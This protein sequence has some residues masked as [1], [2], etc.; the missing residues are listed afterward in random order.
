MPIAR[1]LVRRH[2]VYYWRRRIPRKLATCYIR[3]HVLVSLLTREPAR[4]RSIAAQLDA[5]FEIIMMSPDAQFLTRKQI[6]AMLRAVV[7]GHLAKLDRVAAAG[8]TAP[9]FDAAEAAC[10]DLRVAWAYRLLDGQ[11]ADAVVRPDDRVAMTQA[12]LTEGDIDFID[13]HLDVLRINGMVPTPHGNLAALVAAQGARP[14]AMNIALAQQVYYRGL[15]LALFETERRYAGVVPDAE[16][17]V[18]AAQ[19]VD[20]TEA[21]AP[22]SAQAQ[23]AVPAASVAAQAPAEP[24]SDSVIA[25]GIVAA[26]ER[27][28]AVKAQDENWDTETQDQARQTFAL[29]NRFLAEERKINGFASLRQSD[30]ASFVMFLRTEIYKYYGKSKSDKTRTI[31]ELKKNAAAKDQTLRGLVGGTLNRHLGHIGQLARYARAQG[32]RIDRE[33][34]FGDLRAE[35]PKNI[36]DRD[37]RNTMP[38]AVTQRVFHA[39]HFIGSASWDRPYEFKKEGLVFH[40]ALFFVPMLLEYTGTRREESCGLCVDDIH[41]DGPIPYIHIGRNELRRIKNPQSVRDIPLHPELLRLNFLKYVDLIRSLGYRRVFPDLYSPTSKSPLGDRFYDEFMP[42]LEWACKMENVDLEFVLHSIRHGFNSRLKAAF[43]PAEERADLMGHSGDSE[44]T[45]RY[46]EAIQL[47]RALDLLKKLPVVTGHLKPQPIRL[48][49]WVERKE[50]A[51]FSRG[52]GR[53]MRA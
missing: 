42:V 53:E 48:L 35:K 44:T 51:P 38:L 31:A 4:A 46:A 32:I 40:R 27:F 1:H 8:K 25:D 18:A 17:V 52:R 15:S 11:G 14:T 47:Q 20:R 41:A 13:R 24:A 30:L 19:R 43:V 39:A 9:F 45:E 36:R 34:D 3:P 49:P 12:G 5:V 33:L 22:V 37:E 10:M 50:V 6:D 16:E 7:E 29:F 21:A 26:G 23:V 28:I 2:A